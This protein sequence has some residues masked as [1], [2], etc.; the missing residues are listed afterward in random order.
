MVRHQRRMRLTR[1]SSGRVWLAA[2]IA[3]LL[4]CIFTAPE[5]LPL[6]ASVG[7]FEMG[8]GCACSGECGSI[9]TGDEWPEQVKVTISGATGGECLEGSCE[10]FDGDYFL[11][12]QGVSVST[13]MCPTP[14]G[15]GTRC[16]WESPAFAACEG[17]ES[18]FFILHTFS[19]NIGGDYQVWVG[20]VDFGVQRASWVETDASAGVLCPANFPLTLT[21]DACADSECDWPPTITVDVV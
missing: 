8:C 6:L 14:A 1:L 21:Q 10:A 19:S 16:D 9:C 17:L 12:F 13:A 3:A 7:A 15:G 18:A 2:I 11:D 4:A 5:Y 20:L